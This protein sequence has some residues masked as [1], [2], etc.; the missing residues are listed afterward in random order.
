MPALRPG[1]EGELPAYV[2]ERALRR[3]QARTCTT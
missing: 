3:T 1:P 2:Q